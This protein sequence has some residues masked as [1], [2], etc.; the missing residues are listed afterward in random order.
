[1]NIP[2]SVQPMFKMAGSDNPAGISTRN[3]LS[4]YSLLSYEPSVTLPDTS[5]KSSTAI[6]KPKTKGNYLQEKLHVF[7]NPA[8]DFIIIDYELELYG[9]LVLI[10]QDGR[11]C[12][13]VNLSSGNNQI[14]IRLN[15]FSP[16]IYIAR[17][18][19]GKKVLSAKFTVN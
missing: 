6:N 5:L 14:L 16:G 11:V 3:L 2:I 10:A 17:I 9:K 18:A 12:Y 19:Q 1:M 15:Y 13:S 8:N 4:A 7:P